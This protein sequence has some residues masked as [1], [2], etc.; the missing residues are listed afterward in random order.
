M[1]FK[2]LKEFADKE[3]IDYIS[4][5][6]YARVEYGED[7]YF[8]LLKGIDPK[9]DQSYVLCY[10]TQDILSRT[11]LPL[12]K[13]YKKDNLKIANQLGLKSA[14]VGESQDLCFVSPE[15]YLQFSHLLA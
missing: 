4:T 14:K 2:L 15:D 11:I 9:K 7:G 5:G 3:K 1:K 12:G 10:L 6:H 13:T 8:K